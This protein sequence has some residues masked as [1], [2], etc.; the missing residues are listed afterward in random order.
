MYREKTLF[1]RKKTNYN[2]RKKSHHR[3]KRVNNE[4]N[5]PQSRFVS[6]INLC[7][8]E[9]TVYSIPLISILIK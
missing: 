1:K 9:S 6:K 5:V 8:N 4:N 2:R 7:S 3:H